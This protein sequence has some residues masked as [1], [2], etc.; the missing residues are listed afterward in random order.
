[1]C[2]RCPERARSGSSPGLGAP[3]DSKLR[4]RAGRSHGRTRRLAV[5]ALL[6]L[7]LGLAACAGASRREPK[8]LGVCA[9]PNNMP[10]SNQREQGFENRIARLLAGE[11]HAELRYTWWAQRRGFA[12]STLNAGLCDVIIGVPSAYELALTT[13][14]YYRS[15]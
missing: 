2:S 10:F 15:T 1:M 9:D 3:T 4:P 8:V 6:L 11:L 14:P 13:R 5:P 7:S 12:R